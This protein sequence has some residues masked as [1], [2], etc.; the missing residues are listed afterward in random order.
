[1]YSDMS[2]Q[3]TESNEDIATLM[4][5]CGVAVE[6]NYGVVYNN[7]LMS[8]GYVSNAYT[9]L[10]TNF[11]YLSAMFGWNHIHTYRAILFDSFTRR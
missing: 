4:Y 6:M 1:M 9:A 3:P 10:A 11:G 7:T 2:A 8:S 5:H